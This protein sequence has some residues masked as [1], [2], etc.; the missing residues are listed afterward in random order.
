MAATNDG[1]SNR[2]RKL[3]FMMSMQ[4]GDM[5]KDGIKRI[6]S[7]FL[8]SFLGMKWNY[9]ETFGFMLYSSKVQLPKIKRQSQ[10]TLPV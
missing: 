1:E 8:K 5:K 7:S 9:R 4:T 2:N 6:K 3:Y 10:M